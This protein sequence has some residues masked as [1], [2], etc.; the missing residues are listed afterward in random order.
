MVDRL[1]GQSAR[2]NG[3]GVQFRRRS[4]LLVAEPLVHERVGEEVAPDLLGGG[5]LRG[6]DHV[7]GFV[8]LRA[9][10]E[11]AGDFELMADSAF[12]THARD[13]DARAEGSSLLVVAEFSGNRHT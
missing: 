3:E 1:T 13:V 8:S 9:E 11:G 7:E 2:S 6:E 10:M 5:R 12:G 4:H